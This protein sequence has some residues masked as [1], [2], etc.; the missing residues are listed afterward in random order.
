MSF[1]DEVMKEVK[2]QEREEAVAKKEKML[3]E[4]QEK[5]KGKQE[6]DSLKDSIAKAVRGIY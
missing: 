2:L 6:E 3:S 1:I 4:R 5:E